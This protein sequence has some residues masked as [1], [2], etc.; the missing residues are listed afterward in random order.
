MNGMTNQVTEGPWNI[1]KT[2]TLR[3][4]PHDKVESYKLKGWWVVN[5]LSHCHHGIYS[6]IMQKPQELQD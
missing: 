4:V 3:Y 5:D 2:F 6:V 1:T